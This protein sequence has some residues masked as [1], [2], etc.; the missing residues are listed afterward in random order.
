LQ[1][2]SADNSP[3][4]R[5]LE[6]A[7]LNAWP[8]LQ[9]I[10]FD[11]WLLRF[12]E[13]YTKRA[14]SVNPL[15]GSTV[16]VAAKVEVCENLY[17]QK[18]LPAVF[19]LTS[20]AYPP[21]LDRFLEARGYAHLD[22]TMVQYLDLREWEGPSPRIAP[23]D[24]RLDD[25]LE[26]F[27]QLQGSLAI[28]GQRTHRRMLAAI[29]TTRFLASMADAG[30]VVACGLGVLENDCFGLF[31]LVTGSDY[32]NRGY[33]RDLVSGL[34]AWAR[35]RGGR[36]AYLQV[37]RTNAPALHLYGK[38]GFREMYTYWYRI[39]ESGG[40]PDDTRAAN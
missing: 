38:L 27:A 4:A 13:G 1:S 16:E 5:R 6:E 8:A 30:Q 15:Y 32:R 19:R 17:A 34:L 37:M 9:Q 40:D 23:T 18:G 11:G 21:G 25:W 26:I 36:H 20:F 14:N 39:C 12:S 33:G 22:P 35:D 31:D 7:S 24:E 2:V 29:P 28:E 3:L 10:L